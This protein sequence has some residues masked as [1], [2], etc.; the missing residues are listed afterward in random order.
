MSEKRWTQD[1][2]DAITDEVSKLEGLTDEQVAEGRAEIES[3]YGLP[4]G[5]LSR[6]NPSTVED[7][8]VETA[9]EAEAEKQKIYEPHYEATMEEV[10][11]MTM[12]QYAKWRAL[13]S[14]IKQPH[15]IEAEER[16][17][18]QAEE[19]EK[20]A[21]MSIEEYE[22]YQKEKALKAKQEAEQEEAEIARLIQEKQKKKFEDLRYKKLQEMSM[23]EYAEYRKMP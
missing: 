18:A 16:A 21:K 14:H 13:G 2:V 11:G 10:E 4:A 19:N 20:I 9:P 17:R 5:M 15:D 22:T 3:K 1:E 7:E 8:L 6:T 23:E 12:G